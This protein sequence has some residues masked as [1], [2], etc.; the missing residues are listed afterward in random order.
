MHRIS[1][2]CTLHIGHCILGT[3]YWAL[4]IGH[5]ILGTAYWTLH[6]GHCILGTAYWAHAALQLTPAD[7]PPAVYSRQAPCHHHDAIKSP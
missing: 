3:A 5:C 1:V 7:S 4:H 6:I 2:T